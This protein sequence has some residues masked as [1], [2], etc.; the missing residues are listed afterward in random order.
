[1]K[2]SFDNFGWYSKVEIP[3]RQT[4]VVPPQ[5]GDPVVGEPYPNFTGYTWI[6]IPFNL[7]GNI[8][9]VRNNTVENIIVATIEFAETL[10]YDEVF[11][12][13]NTP[14]GIGW[15]KVD[16]VW[17]APP[18]PAPPVVYKSILTP[19]E[20][21]MR[22]TKE[23]WFCVEDKSATDRDV[24]YFMTMYNKAQEINLDEQS[25]I[26]GVGYL[27]VIGC[28]SEG[29]AAEILTKYPV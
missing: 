1:M 7:I 14:V 3:N 16:G 23:E 27:E 21:L 18:I 6:M 22:F 25:T 29:R 15:I 24:R 4:D 20:F 5:C 19:Y 10:G 12:V 8:A 28:L 2:Y 9:L 11:D 26:D 13:K 17:Q